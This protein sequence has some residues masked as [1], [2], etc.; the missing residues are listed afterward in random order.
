[1]KKRNLFLLPAL[2]CAFQTSALA[3]THPDLA[4]VAAKIDTQ[5]E[6]IKLNKVSG[7]MA[8]ITQYLELIL[9]TARKSG[10]DIPANL[11]AKDVMSILGID[12]LRAYGDS[13]AKVDNAWLNLSYMDN[14]GNKKGV[15]SLFGEK[16][17]AYVVPSIAPA[18]SDLVLQ[19]QLDLRQVE[20]M[21]TAMAKAVGEGDKID[22]NMNKLIPELGMTAAQMLK[23][24]NVRVNFMMDLDAAD[25]IPTP[26]GDVGRPYM[27]ARVDGIAWLWDKVGQKALEESGAPIDV[28][29]KDGLIILKPNLEARTEM[30]EGQAKQ[31]AEVMNLSPI[32]IIDT[33]NNH[34]WIGT[35]EAFLT[36]CMSGES[37][38][39]D[40]AEFKSAMEG[41]PG[42]AN[43]MAYVS[44]EL[45]A[46]ISEKYQK[47]ADTGMLPEEFNMAKPLADR[48]MEDITES[49]KGWAMTVTVDDNGILTA[50]RGPLATKHL[51][52]LGGMLPAMSGMFTGFQKNQAREMMRNAPGGHDHAEEHD[53]GH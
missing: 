2:T 34:V 36:K 30:T 25:G 32:A 18:G 27:A 39:A 31:I 13:S 10:E 50:S 5:A 16:D 35:N 37:T 29:E 23:K 43:T 14:G 33:K 3:Q 46:Q 19:L 9:D 8:A 40:S 42:K 44:K 48:L 1:M 17:Q 15:F 11:K 41:L 24:M 53:H 51:E 47:L 28:S 49:D 7:D 20:E 4:G 6:Y 45:L 12:T 26:F 52:Y 22:E 38:L 21:V